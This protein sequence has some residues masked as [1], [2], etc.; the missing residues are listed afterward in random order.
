MPPPAFSLV[1]LVMPPRCREPYSRKKASRSE[2][3]HKRARCFGARYPP[4]FCERC[5]RFLVALYI[6]EDYLYQLNFVPD[7]SGMMLIGVQSSD[8]LMPRK[9]GLYR[10]LLEDGLD[11]LPCYFYESAC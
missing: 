7:T 5:W 10:P 8:L 4:V 6:S 11:V 2:A 3:L 1:L 9:G